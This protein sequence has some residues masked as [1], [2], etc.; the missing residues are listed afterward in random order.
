MMKFCLSATHIL[1]TR[2]YFLCTVM[3]LHDINKPE[4]NR[5]FCFQRNSRPSCVDTIC[6]IAV[7]L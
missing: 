3:P 4:E 2:C 6:K 1:L 7:V 5:K